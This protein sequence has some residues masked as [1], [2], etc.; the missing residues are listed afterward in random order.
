MQSSKL[1][2]LHLF[3]YST[4]SMVHERIYDTSDSEDTCENTEM[5]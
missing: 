1:S 2:D 5:H 3:L 4:M